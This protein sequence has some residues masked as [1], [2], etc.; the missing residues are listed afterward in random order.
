MWETGTLYSLVATPTT[1]KTP[2]TAKKIHVHSTIKISNP[3]K[4]KKQ[5]NK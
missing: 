2:A 3:H 4:L 1:A 5:K